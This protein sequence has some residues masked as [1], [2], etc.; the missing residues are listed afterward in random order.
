[1]LHLNHPHPD[2]PNAWRDHANPGR[3][4]YL[5]D[6]LALAVADSGDA[7]A[8]DHLAFFLLRYAGDFTA[9][10]GGLLQIGLTLERSDRDRLPP[11]WQPVSFEQALMRLRLRSLLSGAPDAAETGLWHPVV[12]SSGHAIT[13]MLFLDQTEEQILQNLVEAGAGEASGVVEVDLR[14]TYRGL[15][16]GQP[17]LVVARREALDGLLAAL[18]G[19]APAAAAQIEAAFLSLVGTGIVTFEA[20]PELPEPGEAGDGKPAVAA[21]EDE[22]LRE[23]ARRA[24]P[25]YFHAV[26]EGDEVRYARQPLPPAMDDVLRWSLAPARSET[27]GH[28][29]SWSISDW[30]ASLTDAADRSRYF[31][32]VNRIAPFAQTTIHVINS[33]PLDPAHLRNVRVDVRYPGPGGV[34]VNQSAV[35]EDGRA[36]RRFSTFYPAMTM[37]FRLEY[38]LT[39]TLAPA[40]AGGF[41]RLWPPVRAFADAPSPVVLEINRTLAGIEFVELTAAAGVFDLCAALEF[42]LWPGEAPD[43]EA[44]ALLVT[45]TAETP[46]A[47]VALPGAPVDGPLYARCR[48]LPPLGLEAAP[49]PLRDGPL[50]GRQLTIYRYQL[51]VLEPDWVTARL[52]EGAAARYAFVAAAF[53]PVDAQPEDEGRLYTV[54]ANRPARHAVWRPSIFETA[55][56]QW[57]SLIAPLAGNGETLPLETSAWTISTALEL[58]LGG[59]EE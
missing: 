41:P 6:R 3:G 11:D 26:M 1:M 18:L 9:A 44:G 37:T 24:L 2:A 20:L 30:H 33:L 36:I 27:R 13:A 40:V 42:S 48:A 58:I 50:T 55:A 47:W 7:P 51:E 35:F 16:D 39:C 38:R 22:L 14:L 53:R 23:A 45:L 32:I 10:T 12:L 46:H 19:D 43:D 31:P 52:A 28:E 25:L 29:L 57:R 17:W 8:E 49:R 5:P 21:S 59:L 56:Y 54:A 4:Y 34:P 15:V